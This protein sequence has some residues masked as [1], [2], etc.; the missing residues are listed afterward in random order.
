MPAGHA[1]I[2]RAPAARL[3]AAGS[4]CRVW[5]AAC[6]ASAGASLHLELRGAGQ[7]TREPGG[8]RWVVRSPWSV[9]ANTSQESGGGLGRVRS[10]HTRQLRELTSTAGAA[11]RAGWQPRRAARKQLAAASRQ[12][13][14]TCL[15]LHTG[16]ACCSC[17]LCMGSAAPPTAAVGGV[18]EGEAHW[19]WARRHKVA[20]GR[21]DAAGREREH[22]LRMGCGWARIRCKI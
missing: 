14:Q 12:H 2:V 22:R 13:S 21:V 17:R 5:P 11:G 7:P 3:R 1:P 8:K 4:I 19:P 16:S 10:C 20:S 18:P 15:L 9:K 6:E